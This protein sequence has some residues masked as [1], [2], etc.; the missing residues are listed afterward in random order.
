MPTFVDTS[1]ILPLLNR[2]DSDYLA[3]RRV[4]QTLAVEQA[5]L[6][7]SSYVMVES[8]ALIQSRLGMD[9]VRDF[10][11]AIAP[12]LQIVWISEAIH[13]KGEAALLTANRRQLSLVDCIS[14]VICHDRRLERVFAF[15]AHF[16]EQGFACL[17]G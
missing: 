5:E 10:E 9:A 7:T 4:W 15:D 6:I 8:V 14:F 3:A 2:A 12:L 13:Q 11:E 1:A 16:A 17:P